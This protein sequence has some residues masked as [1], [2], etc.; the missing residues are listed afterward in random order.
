MNT[1]RCALRRSSDTG[2]PTTEPLDDAIRLEARRVPN[3]DHRR[4]IRAHRV[5]RPHRAPEPRRALLAIEQRRKRRG[6][7]LF[8]CFEERVDGALEIG[9]RGEGQAAL[10]DGSGGSGRRSAIAASIT[11]R[12]E[13]SE[14]PLR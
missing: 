6:A 2:P 3:V 11:R 8:E 1:V 13:Y 12:R 7:E 5:D 10:R 14:P 9:E 4:A